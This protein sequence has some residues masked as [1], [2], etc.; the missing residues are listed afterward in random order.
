MANSKQGVNWTPIIII[1]GVLLWDKIFGKDA[2]EKAAEEAINK[3]ESTPLAN[4]PF[5]Y[6]NFKLAIKKGA[7][8]F[9]LTSTAAQDA[10]KQIYKGV[11]GNLVL[12]VSVSENEDEMIAGIKKAGTKA[13]IVLIAANYDNLYHADLYAVLKKYLNESE[14]GT[15]TGFVNKLPNYVTNGTLT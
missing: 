10:A 3:L 6:K 1:G 15:V 13:D 5:S 4:N 12:D 7:Y 2:A 11:Q 9:S 8:R 14:L